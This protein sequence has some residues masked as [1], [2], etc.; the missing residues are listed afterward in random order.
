LN[1][2]LH[3]LRMKDVFSIQEVYYAILET[4]GELSVLKKAAFESATKQDLNLPLQQ[5]FVATPV[6]MDGEMIADNLG[7]IDMTEEQVSQA[8]EQQHN[9]TDLHDVFYAEFVP[10]QPL[11]V[12]PYHKIKHKD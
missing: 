5:T 10:G 4:N 6:I 7:E 12:L 8:L 2:V 3:L 9:I 1:E 11:F